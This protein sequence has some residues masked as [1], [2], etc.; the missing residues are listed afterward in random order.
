MSAWRYFGTAI[1]NFTHATTY[2]AWR[3]GLFPR[4]FCHLMIRAIRH[5]SPPPSEFISK[6][7]LDKRLHANLTQKQLASKLGVSV[8]TVKNWESGRT[9]PGLEIRRELMHFFCD[10]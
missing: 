5:D 3:K 4:P 6:L 8:K 10:A 2:I 1:L 9:K 7:L